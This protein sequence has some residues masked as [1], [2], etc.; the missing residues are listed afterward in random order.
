MLEDTLM[1]GF[2]AMDLPCDARAL[3][4]FRI[5]YDLLEEKNRVMNLTAINGEDESATRHF[6]D[7]AAPALPESSRA[8]RRSSG[9]RTPMMRPRSTVGISFA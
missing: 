8:R 1:R 9:V 3:E 7:S 5:Y 4:R 2:E 6:L